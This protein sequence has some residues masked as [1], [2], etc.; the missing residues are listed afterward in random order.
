MIFLILP[1]FLNPFDSQWAKGDG[2]FCVPSQLIRKTSY[3]L[4]KNN[5]PNHLASISEL[6]IS[7]FSHLSPDHIQKLLLMTCSKNNKQYLVVLI[8]YYSTLFS[9]TIYI[10]TVLIYYLKCFQLIN[11]IYLDFKGANIHLLFYLLPLCY[12]LLYFIILMMLCYC[13]RNIL[14]QLQLICFEIYF[15]IQFSKCKG[16]CK[17]IYYYCYIHIWCVHLKEF[18]LNILKVNMFAVNNRNYPCSFYGHAKYH[19]TITIWIV[20]QNKCYSKKNQLIPP[21]I[22]MICLPSSNFFWFFVDDQL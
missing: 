13:K 17:N 12:Y 15:T 4:R 18:P 11:S 16:I 2:L 7:T 22:C 9:V 6:L 10:Q 3:T 20:L 14:S 5:F 19:Y 21:V 1:Q 8:P